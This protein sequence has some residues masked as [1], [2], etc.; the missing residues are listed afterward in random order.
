VHPAA[1]ETRPEVGVLDIGAYENGGTSAP[2]T[3]DPPA[4]GPSGGD[5]DP[6]GGD[7][8]PIPPGPAGADNAPQVPDDGDR[9]TSDAVIHNGADV[10]S[11]CA[12]LGPPGV[13]GFG[14]LIGLVGLRLA[15]RR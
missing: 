7:N 6:S 1:A 8:A 4:P 10:S 14:I 2:L 3:G 12:A 9:G 5:S 15:R 11:S 13:A